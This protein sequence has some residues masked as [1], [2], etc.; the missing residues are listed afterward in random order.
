MWDFTQRVEDVNQVP[1]Q[2][3]PMYMAGEG[4]AD[5]T[6][7]VKPDFANI[8]EAVNGLNGSLKAARQEAKDA[9]ASVA[10]WASLGES[11]DAVSQSITNLTTERNEALDKNKSF[12]PEKITAQ[13]A[14]EYK[15][16]IAGFEERQGLLTGALKKSLVDSAASVAIAA[17]KGTPEL[18]MPIIQ[19]QVKMTE[20]DGAFGVQVIDADGSVRYSPTSG[21]LMTVDE[22]V[23]ELKSHPSYG[24]AFKSDMKRGPGE[25]NSGRRGLHGQDT[26]KMTSTDKISAG[27]GQ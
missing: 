6:F 16:K 20:K 7:V 19:Q 5:G 22:L 2:F 4:E 24:M 23:K 26:S 11:P 14:G 18:L 17:H 12:D 3:R 13:I 9:K 1:E 8:V 25:L 10:G 21:G 15:D 27:L